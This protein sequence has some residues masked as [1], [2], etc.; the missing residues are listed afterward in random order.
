VVDGRF[1][2]GFAV[3]WRAE[4]GFSMVKRGGFVVKGWLED[5]ANQALKICQLFEIFLW[6]FWEA[7]VRSVDGVFAPVRL[8]SE[9]RG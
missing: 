3:F 9:Y 1:C 6:F 7:R 8:L 4:R 2:R 5:A